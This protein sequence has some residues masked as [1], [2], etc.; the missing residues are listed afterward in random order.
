VDETG[1]DHLRSRYGSVYGQGNSRI[2]VFAAATN[3]LL[4]LNMSTTMPR[5]GGRVQL[6]QSNMHLAWNMAKMANG[7]FSR[8]AV[9]ET[10]YLIKKP[11]AE[12]QEEQKRSVEFPWHN[13]VKDAIARHPAML[14]QNQTPGCLPCQND[15]SKSPQ[16]RCRRKRT[17]APPPNRRRQRNP[18]PTTEPTPEPTPPR[19]GTALASTGNTSGDQ[20]LEIINL[21]PVIRISILLFHVL[22]LLCSMHLPRKASTIQIL[23]QICCLMN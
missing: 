23:I 21:P 12:V 22:N 13:K 20:C 5:Q 1:F 9:E 11:H 19:P 10:Q 2:S 4:V 3:F 15:T 7:G 8:A 6:E 17:G 16:T 18:A 14:R